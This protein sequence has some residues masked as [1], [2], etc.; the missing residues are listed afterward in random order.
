MKY[1][2]DIFKKL[3]CVTLFLSCNSQNETTAKLTDVD[4]INHTKLA[5]PE[6]R[7]DF[8]Q[9]DFKNEF[10]SY[11]NKNKNK[12]TTSPP[13]NGEYGCEVERVLICDLNRDG[14][15]DG[16]I[17]YSFSGNYGNTTLSEI[18]VVISN[19][20]KLSGVVLESKIGGAG[21]GK[22]ID[23][24]DDNGI[25]E[26]SRYEWAPDDSHAGGPSI[27]IREQYRLENNQLKLYKKLSR[28]QGGAIS[29]Y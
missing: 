12:L 6:L 11:F 10:T 9:K 26:I 24:I 4:T 25:I 28:E 23:N 15:N 14:Y 3:I 2:L 20:G 21:T 13:E 22:T 19:N 7:K 17:N 27:T 29:S 5:E 18:G 16:L 8:T 1:L